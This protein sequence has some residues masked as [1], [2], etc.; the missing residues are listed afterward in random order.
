MWQ[1][2]WERLLTFNFNLELFSGISTFF[3][4]SIKLKL[5]LVV[6]RGIRVELFKII[7]GL[8]ENAKRP[9]FSALSGSDTK[10]K[11][12]Y[13][14]RQKEKNGSLDENRVCQPDYLTKIRTTFKNPPLRVN[15]GQTRKSE[16]DTTKGVTIFPL[17]FCRWLGT[18]EALYFFSGAD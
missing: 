2:V 17:L 10:Y 15:A 12:V 11:L 4:N 14:L 6:S 3:A 7:P 1:H 9:H 16:R 5:C 13:F 18:W 8:C